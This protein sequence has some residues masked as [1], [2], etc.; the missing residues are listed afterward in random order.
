LSVESNFKHLTDADRQLARLGEL[1]ER[2]FHIDPPTSIGKTRSFAELLAKEIAARSGTTFDAYTTSQGLLRRLRDDGL[3]PRDVSEWFHYIRRV[4]NAAIHENEG[5]PGDALT[6]LKAAWQLG[7]WFRRAFLSEPKFNTG[8]FQPPQSPADAT[9]ELRAEIEHLRQA[10]LESESAAERSRR[11]AQE[12]ELARASAE[13]RAAREAENR[14]AAEDLVEEVDAAR[15]QTERRLAELQAAAAL[16][17]PA[18]LVMFK[19]AAETAA[20]DVILDE[21]DTRRLID[22]QLR[23]AG[24]TVDSDTIRYAAGSRPNIANAIAIAEWPTETGPVDYALFLKGRCVGVIEAKRAAKDVPSVLE[25]AKRCA[26][27]I[28]LK[29]DETFPGAPYQQGEARPY[30]VPLTFAT[31]GRP[32]VKQLATKSGIWIW[33]ARKKANAPSALPAWFSPRDVEERLQ[34]D[35]QAAQELAAE[36]FSYGGLHPYQQDA[37]KAVSLT[38]LPSSLKAASRQSTGTSITAFGRCCK[39]LTPRFGLGRHDASLWSTAAGPLRR[40]WRQ[41]I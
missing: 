1:A 13:E 6:A 19:T 7:I 12:A 30:R 32:F 31:N 5:T 20:D 24:W 28:K 18:D 37:V 9:I 17:R 38:S 39:T 34:Q 36:S 8:P 26:L 2:L 15:Q 35:A 29:G 11:E 25:Q 10:V 41:G 22:A 21:A 33:D 4:G 16:M 3:L 23:E 14:R 27:G 40:P